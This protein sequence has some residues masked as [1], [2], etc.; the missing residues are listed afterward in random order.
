MD[1]ETKLVFG[2]PRP[3]P[4]D[5][6][7]LSSLKKCTNNDQFSPKIVTGSGTLYSPVT[8]LALNLGEVG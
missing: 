3:S 1:S 4:R 2:P 8:D 6:L 7:H 5:F